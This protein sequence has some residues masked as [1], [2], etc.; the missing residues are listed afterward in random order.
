[1]VLSGPGEVPCSETDASLMD[2]RPTVLD[3]M[4]VKPTHSVDGKPLLSR[5]ELK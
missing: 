3:W 2:I 5:L 4:G 1:M